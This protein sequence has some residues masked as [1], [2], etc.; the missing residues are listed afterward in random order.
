MVWSISMIYNPSSIGKKWIVVMD[1]R[2]GAGVFR[3]EAGCTRPDPGA[4]AGLRTSAPCTARPQLDDA[5]LDTLQPSH[6]VRADDDTA[7]D[8]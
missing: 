6:S 7:T 1:C 5:G 4:T 2:L 8:P 3:S